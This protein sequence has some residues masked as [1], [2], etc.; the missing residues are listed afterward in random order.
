METILKRAAY[1]QAILER[2]LTALAIVLIIGKAE[3][4]IDLRRLWHT[5]AVELL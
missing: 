5:F 1:I 2:P 3:R 4:L